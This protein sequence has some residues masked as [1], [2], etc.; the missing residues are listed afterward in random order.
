RLI[1][2]DFLTLDL[3]RLGQGPYAVVSNLPYAV[4]SPILRRLL[5]WSG[6]SEAVLMFQKEVALRVCAAPG[7]A[8]YGLLSLA[9]QIKAEPE[10]LFELPP[11]A[12]RPPPRVTSGV[13]RLRRRAEPLVSSEEE[14]GFFR[15]AREAFAQRR[16]MAASSLSRALSRPRS[17]VE[18][19]LE[20]RGVSARARPQDIPLAVWIALSRERR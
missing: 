4:A 5:D 10:W 7:G 20:G 12:F 1:H 11:S 9:A 3:G 15:L 18:R 19:L 13:I 17:E 16:K 6:W 14:P 2:A 8:D